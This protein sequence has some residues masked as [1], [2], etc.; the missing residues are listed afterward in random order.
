MTQRSPLSGSFECSESQALSSLRPQCLLGAR[1]W[2]L[3]QGVA[4][5]RTSKIRG[6]LRW[7]RHS[8]LLA[9]IQ[10]AVG[11]DI[12]TVS[13]CPFEDALLTIPQFAV[14]QKKPGSPLGVLSFINKRN[15]NELKEKFRIGLLEF[16]REPSGT[17]EGVPIG[18]IQGSELPDEIRVT[19]STWIRFPEV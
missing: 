1:A 15:W 10:Q 5:E 17:K 16:R 14:T 11:S 3:R 6:W 9:L 12:S 19:L 8:R 4:I 18:A 13:I 2:A 7:T